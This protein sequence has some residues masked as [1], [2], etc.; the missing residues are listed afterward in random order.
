MTRPPL[1]PI[2]RRV[3]SID[4]LFGAIATAFGLASIAYPF[5]RDQS[6]FFYA[7]REWVERGQV[8]YRDVWD[9]KP[10]VIYFI[11]MLII[12]VL[13]E[14]EWGIRVVELVVAVPATAWVA[15]RLATPRGQPIAPGTFGAAWLGAAIFQYGYLTY[16]DTG[17]CEIWYALFAVSGMTAILRR[18][19]QPYLVGGALAG[20]ALF[21]KPPAMS[22]VLLCLVAMVVRVHADR[23]K[24]RELA[25]AARAFALAG[26]AVAAA[27]LGLM[28]ALH[29]VRPMMDIL[30]GANRTYL[31]DEAGVSGVGDI[32]SRAGVAFSLFR[33]F[34]STFVLIVGMTAFLGYTRRDP[35]LGTRYAWALLL[36]LATLASVVM[37]LK[38]YPYHWGPAIAPAALFFALLWEDCA[39]AAR[40]QARWVAPMALLVFASCFFLLSGHPAELWYANV[41]DTLEY[42]RHRIDRAAFASSFDI[43]GF[44][45][46][47]EAELVASWLRERTCSKDTVVVRGFEPEIYALSGLHFTGRFFW[48][49]FLTNSRRRY[50]RDEL[51]A[52]DRAE[53]VRHPPR[54]AVALGSTDTAI[55]SAGWFEELGYVRRVDIG[56]FVVLERAGA[57]IH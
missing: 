48:T 43:P 49:T 45:S 13:G 16:W 21:T 29:A 30:V 12:A 5:G 17:Q 28:T 27:I 1:A 40:S 23:G 9:H 7:A 32:L 47:S 10:P 34:S 55:D 53:M 44:Y 35:R 52:E 56:R 37:Q 19:R 20:L 3:C 51:L 24:V 54:Y 18:E 50:H 8:L 36:A 26:C 42:E 22:F 11:H 6:L 2:L 31:T 15:A 46:E 4:A 57:N 38:F 25:R 33:P 14:H 41:R 39:L